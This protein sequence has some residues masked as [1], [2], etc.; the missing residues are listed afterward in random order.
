MVNAS[1]KLSKPP[2]KK[3]AIICPTS[4]KLVI[5]KPGILLVPIAH[6]RDTVFPLPVCLS[7]I[8][9]TAPS[10]QHGQLGHES[11]T[12]GNWHRIGLKKDYDHMFWSYRF[13]CDRKMERM[14]RDLLMEFTKNDNEREWGV[15]AGAK[16]GLSLWSP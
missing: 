9:R 12:Q 15:Y 1:S 7:S 3:K 14:T 13:V 4:M 10:D 2:K 8:E 16:Q 5:R 6:A 11:H